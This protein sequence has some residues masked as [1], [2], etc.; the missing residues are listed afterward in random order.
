VSYIEGYL[1]KICVTAGSTIRLHASGNGD[2][3]TLSLLREGAP[4]VFVLQ[5]IPI[6]VSEHS[7]P[8]QAYEHGP[9]WPV[10]WEFKVPDDWPSAAYRIELRCRDDSELHCPA[11]R[12]YR[13]AVHPILMVIRAKKPTSQSTILLQLASNTYAAYNDWGGKSTYGYNSP[14]GQAAVVSMQRPGTGMMCHSGFIYW[15]RDFIRFCDQQ[16]IAIELATNHELH[17]W[18]DGFD[19]YRLILSVGHDE[20]WSKG[21]RDNLEAFIGNGGNAA[22]FSGNSVCWQVRYENDGRQLVTYKENYIDDPYYADKRYDELTALWSH[23]LINRTENSLTGVGFPAGGYHLSHGAYM[24]G[25]G[26]FTVHAP[27]HWIF[28]GTGLKAGDKLGAKNTILGYECDGCRFS[29]Q[30]GRP[31]PV[32]DDGTPDTFEILAQGPARWTG[33]DTGVYQEAGVQEEGMACMGVYTRNG[34]VFTAA[35]TDWSNALG[36]DPVVDRITLNILERLT[37]PSSCLT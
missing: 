4:D 13:D 15:E 26:A 19:D 34:T 31:V 36:R 25:D 18:P 30:D 6:P 5:D 32:C 12:G 17:T 2:K 37:A 28:N 22:F 27:E 3:N 35:S 24:D 1:E 29:V 10:V 11:E 8:P 14:G 23:P 33:Y 20:Y 9:G 16:N 7:I 21:M